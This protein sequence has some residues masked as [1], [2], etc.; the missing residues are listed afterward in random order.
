MERDL[1]RK[2]RNTSDVIQMASPRFALN[3]LSSN[4]GSTSNTLQFLRKDEG[5]G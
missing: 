3:A 1:E 2:E 5:K 4:Y